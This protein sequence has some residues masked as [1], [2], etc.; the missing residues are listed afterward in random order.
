[1]EIQIT[2]TI[3]GEMPS[4]EVAAKAV[5]KATNDLLLDKACLITSYQAVEI[6]PGSQ[7]SIAFP[8]SID[9]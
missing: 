1:M 7:Y 6:R 4:V 3:K 5:Y 9:T 2:L 8:Q